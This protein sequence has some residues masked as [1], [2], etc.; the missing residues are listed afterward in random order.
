MLTRPPRRAAQVI[1]G[2]QPHD[3]GTFD[4]TNTFTTLVS[5]G[6]W[7]V[8]SADAARRA[9]QVAYIVPAAKGAA[10]LACCTPK[11]A[12]GPILPCT[13]SEALPA[14]LASR[15]CGL[16]AMRMRAVRGA[17]ARAGLLSRAPMAARSLL[18]TAHSDAACMLLL[19]GGVLLQPTPIVEPR[20]WC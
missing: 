11:P 10:A 5:N 19:L 16:P 1:L 13:C 12:D 3:D 8:P 15:G 20:A 6:A 17:A 9:D 4:R 7:S 14:A 2:S 18:T